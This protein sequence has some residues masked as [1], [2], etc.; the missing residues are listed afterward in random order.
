M[1][2]ARAQHVATVIKPALAKGQCVLCDRFIDASYAYQGGGRGLAMQDI[3][4]LEQFVLKG[5][6][7]DLTFIFYAPVAVGLQRARG[8]TKGDRI[9]QEKQVFFE[10]VQQTY[11]ARAKKNPQRYRLLD[12]KQTVA[13]IQQ[14]LQ[15][16]LMQPVVLA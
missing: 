14:D 1:W 9:E 10:Q 13:D 3:A 5:L 11:L 12:A 16:L 8:H 4:Q 6:Q 7:P 15:A 2:A